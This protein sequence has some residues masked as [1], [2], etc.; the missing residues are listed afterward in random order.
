MT[1]IHVLGD[2]PAGA[3]LLGG[4]GNALDALVRAGKQVPSGFVL[5]TMATAALTEGKPWP[6][7]IASAF[8]SACDGLIGDGS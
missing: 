2:G 1:F 6:P 4:K 8:A 3:A 5:T 7:E